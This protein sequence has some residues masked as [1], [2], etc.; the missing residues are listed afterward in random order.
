MAST[1]FGVVRRDGVPV[2]WVSDEELLRQELDQKW[3]K[4]KIEKM[5]DH[6]TRKVRASKTG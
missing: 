1:R 5:N 4:K 2:P 3:K 6:P